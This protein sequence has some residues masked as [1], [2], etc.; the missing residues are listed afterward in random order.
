MILTQMF[1]NDYLHSLPK[2]GQVAIKPTYIW[3]IHTKF[4]RKVANT[5]MFETK[6]Y[7]QIRFKHQQK[8]IIKTDINVNTPD[9]IEKFI[10]LGHAFH[11]V[12]NHAESSNR[13]SYRR[14]IYKFVECFFEGLGTLTH[15]ILEDNAKISTG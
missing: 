12:F 2:I 1:A 7:R 6:H 3:L 15:S 10:A 13:H 8:R 14:G 11:E 5:F 9:L 4:C